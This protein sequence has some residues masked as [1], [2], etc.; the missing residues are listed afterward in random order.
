MPTVL[1]ID[2]S[3]DMAAL[4]GDELYAGSFTK[5]TPDSFDASNPV[6]ASP[7]VDTY[8]FKGIAFSYAIGD[9]DSEQVTQGS[10]R[11]MILLGTILDDDDAPAPGI[12]PGP[13][14]SISIAP[15]GQSTPISGTVTGPVSLNQ[16]QCTVT[17]R[18]PS[19]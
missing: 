1:G 16:A 2:W 7:D 10:W 12:V 18:G 17:V 15:P 6:S 5:S 13:G 14:D 3:A 11:V 4:L 19:L 8:T 9:L